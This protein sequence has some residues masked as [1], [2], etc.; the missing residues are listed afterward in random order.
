SVSDVFNTLHWTSVSDFAG[1]YL[2]AS[3]NQESR[4]LKIYFTYKF[5]N[6]QV[7]T[8][9]VRKTGAD[10]ESKRVGS[11]GGGLSN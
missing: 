3:G 2:R 10:E 4:Q 9:R 5:G 11:Q 7:K 1:Q 8:A 6:A